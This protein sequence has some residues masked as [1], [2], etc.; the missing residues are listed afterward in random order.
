MWFGVRAYLKSAIRG[1]RHQCEASQRQV[2]CLHAAPI[3]ARRLAKAAC[4]KR[5]EAAKAG[6]SDVHAH[7]RHGSSLCREQLLGAIEAQLNSILVRCA[8]LDE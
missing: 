1:G 3:S 8:P 6:E 4:E 7:R 5:A 2:H